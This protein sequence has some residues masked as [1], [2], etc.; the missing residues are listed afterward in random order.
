MADKNRCRLWLPVI[1][2][3]GASIGYGSTTASGNEREST[4]T[5]TQLSADLAVV[6]QGRILFSHHSVGVNIIMGVKRFDAEIPGESHI[7]LASLAEAAT[8]RGPMLIDFTGGKNGEPKTK[9]D[10][11]AAAIRGESQLKP[12]LAFMKFCYVD[13]NPRT[14]VD[15]LFGYYR[16]T[17]E[18]LKHEH[19]EIRFA[20]VTVPLT[21][22]PTELKWRIFRLIGKEVW[23]DA[24]NV[25]R[26]EFNRR[27]KE[28][29]GT[30]LLFDLAS[31]E[32][33]APDGRLTAFEQDG[34]SY[35]S[36][37]PGYTEDGGHLN[38]VG[39]QVVGA[40]AIRFMAEGLKGRGTKQ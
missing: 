8:S 13:F 36:L 12:D 4:M 24:A 6:R 34:R 33:T 3:L 29:F 10:A 2:L 32:A 19:P 38:L 31:I 23:E 20:H 22:W 1:L 15:D 39:Q 40:A 7:R 30:D 25:K 27:L 18:A 28:S 17:V 14:D 11:F 37:Y 35:L 16:K 26:A 5:T 9:I 21:T